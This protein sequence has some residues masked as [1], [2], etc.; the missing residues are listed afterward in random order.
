MIRFGAWSTLLAVLALQLLVLAALLLRAPANRRANACLALLLVV[1]TGMLTPY[2]LGYAGAYDAFPWLTSAPL[3]VP[4]AVGPLLFAH[5]TALVDG[6]PL[7]LWHF[8]PAGLQFGM[9]GLLFPFPVETKWWWDGA[10]QQPYLSPLLS[11]AVLVSMAAYAAAS[12]RALGRYEAWLK[13]RRRD[14][15]PA[16]RVRLAAL[17]LATLLAARAGYELFDALVRPIDYFDL[18]AFYILV[19]LIG[20]VLGADGWRNAHAA[21]PAVTEPEARD[22]A[23]Q[24]EA[25]LARLREEGWWRDPELELPRLARLL[26]TNTAHLSRALNEAGDGFA[27]ALAGIRADAV[28]AAIA[29]G[30][31]RDLLG[32]ALE[33][34]FGSKA[35]FNRAFRARFGL[36]PRDY[37]DRHG[38][39]GKSSSPQVAVRRAPA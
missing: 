36:S 11:L 9:Q 25:W 30:D 6:R 8:A 39:V 21:A 35:T 32:L 18:F 17:A 16:R 38:A 5:V 13:A 7:P 15:R 29:A 31:S 2:V 37:R 27:A 34:G 1:L 10:V 26:G 24:G 4:L 20:L 12:W 19:G 3:A 14:P 23:A 22:W 33:A 28:A